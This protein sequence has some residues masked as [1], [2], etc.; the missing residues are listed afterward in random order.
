MAALIVGC[1]P[2]PAM[3]GVTVITG[4]VGLG[5]ISVAPTAGGFMWATRRLSG[6]TAVPCGVSAST[7]GRAAISTSK[8]AGPLCGRASGKD[9]VREL[10]RLYG[11][12][13]AFR[14]EVAMAGQAVLPLEGY[15]FNCG[16]FLVKIS[17]S[18][19]RLAITLFSGV[20]GLHGGPF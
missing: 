2:R 19:F 1:R 5:L 14:I 3:Q 16:H 6:G 12:S 11:V 17:F 9:A 15:V 20:R 18:G 4:A 7:G 8:E 10:Q 13:M